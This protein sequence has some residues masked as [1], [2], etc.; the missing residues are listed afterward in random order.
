MAA[1]SPLDSFSPAVRSLV[2]D[3]SDI[4]F[5]V[6]VSAALLMSGPEALAPEDAQRLA[7]LHYAADYGD[8]GLAKRLLEAGADPNAVFAEETLLT[9]AARNGRLEVARELI[10]AGADVNLR[11]RAGTPLEHA[12]AHGHQAMAQ[13]LSRSGAER[14]PPQAKAAR[15]AKPQTH[16]AADTSRDVSA[17][18]FAAVIEELER[19]TGVTSQKLDDVEGG[20]TFRVVPGRHVRERQDALR[21]RGC[22]VF[23][24]SIDNVDS[25]CLALL[26]TS[27][28]LEAVRRVGTA[29]ENW[30]ID[31]G[32][33]VEWLGEVMR[34]YPLRLT[35]IGRDLIEGTFAEPIADAR[36]L[37]EK[38]VQILPGAGD[39]GIERLVENLET[40]RELFLFWD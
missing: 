11:S 9:V 27:D 28:F 8:A 16:T 2:E 29:G 24:Y 5:G 22:L 39:W 34:Q 10:R 6:M 7:L 18:E 26:P 25:G 15:V 35:T 21:K 17:E 19:A 36:G 30:R 33:I 31:N 4:P 40:E 20:V 37:A 3:E 14:A 23:N 38:I 13:L 1:K 12:E 32:A